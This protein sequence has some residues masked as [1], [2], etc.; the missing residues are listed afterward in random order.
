MNIRA[1]VMIT[2]TSLLAV[3]TSAVQ[4]GSH[5]WDWTEVFSNADGTI[6][7]MELQECC[8]NPN[9]VGVGGHD[10]TSDTQSMLT[11]A[12]GLAPPTSNKFYLI[13]T[14]AF[15]D[16]PGAP[17]PDAI[18]PA[19][20]IPFFSTSGDTLAYVPWDTWSF[21][22]L[23]TDGVTSLMRDGST[24]ANTPTNYAGQGGSVD[25]SGDGSE[26]VPAASEWGLLVL[27]LLV[28][29]AGSLVFCRG[30]SPVL[31]A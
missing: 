4:A 28:L 31:A 9:E 15:A 25:A 13:A 12:G 26:A 14:Q 6:Q 19:G 20:S 21:G 23:P 1:S 24:G 30:R 2:L 10:I 16:L 7:F 8:G 18:I 5:T 27:S 22:A 29:S 17:T 11:P 3:G